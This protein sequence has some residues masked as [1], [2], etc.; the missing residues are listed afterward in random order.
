M[1][2]HKT[3]SIKAA[4]S[5]LG[6][7]EAVLSRG[8]DEQKPMWSHTGALSATQR[9]RLTNAVSEIGLVDHKPDIAPSSKHHF[10]RDQITAAK[11]GSHRLAL[12]RR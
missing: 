8:Y 3:E 11:R 2:S 12:R 10:C 6:Q 9:E 5:I 4:V 7:I 1:D